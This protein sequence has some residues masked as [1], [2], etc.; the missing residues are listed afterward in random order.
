MTYGLATLMQLESD[1]SPSPPVWACVR[2]WGFLVPRN[3]HTG[4]GRGLVDWAPPFC[5]P[6]P[7]SHAPL[8]L[9][10]PRAAVWGRT[11]ND[12]IRKFLQFQL[13]VNVAGPSLDAPR[14]SFLTRLRLQ[15]V[16]PVRG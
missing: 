12:N 1:S 9:G 15:D 4:L 14:T 13:T 8:I 7:P 11:V 3:V 5:T 16:E 10:V 2:P 6:P